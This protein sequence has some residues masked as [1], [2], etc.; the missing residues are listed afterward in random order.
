M[1]S[2]TPYYIGL[3]SGT[4]LDGIDGVLLS[5]TGKKINLIKHAEIAYP[6]A[7]QQA[8][9]ALF[10]PAN[11]EIERSQ[12]AG[13]IRAELAAQLVD[14]LCCDIDRSQVRAIAD[15]G[16]TVR[17]CPNVAPPYS[18][19]IHQGARL[20]ELSSITTVVDFRSKDIASGGQGAP[21]VPA[22]HQAFFSCQKQHRLIVNIGG[23]CNISLL[24][25]NDTQALFGFDT[26]PGNTLMDIWATQ[27][28]NKAYDHHGNWACSGEVNTALLAHFMEDDYFMRTP[29]KSTGRE[30]FNLAWL[31]D[32]LATFKSR[33]KGPLEANDVQARLNRTHCAQPDAGH[34]TGMRTSRH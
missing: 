19:Q 9:F 32:K 13:I 11:N 5:F 10:T 21:L 29:P 7:L 30:H 6:K 17:H 16:Q 22:F 27:H 12:L 18:V 34:C 2:K 23:I 24:K 28:I 25:P 33:N 26:G 4:S 8:F 3:M 31:T 20:A 14:T 15:H 1:P